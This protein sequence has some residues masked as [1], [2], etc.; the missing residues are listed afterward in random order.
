VETINNKKFSIK[1]Q[2]IIIM[3]IITL[4]FGYIAYDFLF[5]DNKVETKVKT[6]QRKLDSLKI[7]L[8]V[9]IPQ[10]DTAITSQEKQLEDLKKASDKYIKK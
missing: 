4:I 5:F 10:I 9:K 2:V 1:A 3:T 8:D 6:V 7:F